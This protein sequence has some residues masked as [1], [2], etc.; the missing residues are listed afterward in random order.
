MPGIKVKWRN[1][2]A[3]AIGSVAESGRVRK[4]LG[5]RDPAQAEELRSQFESTLWKRSTYGEE[6]VRTFEEAAVSYLEAGGE[7]T[8]LPPLIKRFRGRRL[9]T[10]KPEELREAARA[11][12]P[13]GKPS[14]RNR[15]GI[16]PA[17]AVIN[18][19]AG[20]G[21]CP[22]IS[23]KNFPVEKV[24][25]QAADRSWLEQFVA[26][27]DQDGLPHL[28]AAVLFMAQNAARVTE[29]AQVMPEDVDLQS[30]V[31]TLRHTKTDEWA[32]RHIT[33]EL[34]LRLANLEMTEGRPVFGYNARF[35]IYRR[36]VA[37]CRRAGLAWRPPH[38]AGRHSY[39]TNALERGAN[40][41][42]VMEGG[43][44]ATSRMVLE[45]YAHAQEG[46]KAIA[47]LFDSDPNRSQPSAISEKRKRNQ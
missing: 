29:A 4:S 19:A 24:R 14:T 18:H 11:I 34:T 15:Q 1:G 37:V 21:W 33:L 8:Y 16:I 43:G 13:H 9:G 10:I 46:G 20:K 35:G 28:A 22:I 31:I 5:T 45:I 6:A 38:Q 23:V 42:Q 41:K 3:Y 44:W 26:R 25:R 27:A 2:V 12:Y 32:R 17:R 40:L 30:R 7:R 47:N 39:A 36:M